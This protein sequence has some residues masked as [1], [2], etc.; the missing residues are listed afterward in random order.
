MMNEYPVAVQLLICSSA[1]P[2]SGA[3]ADHRLLNQAY[4]DWEFFTHVD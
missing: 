3:R 4:L 1:H 2:Q